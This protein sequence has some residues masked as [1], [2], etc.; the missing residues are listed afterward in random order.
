M[1]HSGAE[2]KGE[3]QGCSDRT[4]RML[5]AG[6]I[7]MDKGMEEKTVVS[8][9][10]GKN[11]PDV[12]MEMESIRTAVAGVLHAQIGERAFQPAVGCR[13]F[14][15]VKPWLD[16][17]DRELACEEAAGTIAGYES[18]VTNVRVVLENAR[19][20]PAMDFLKVSWVVKS[21]G[22]YDELVLSFP[23]GS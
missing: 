21:T 13:P 15:P 1:T 10:S 2:R 8:P 18:R 7:L 20:N 3:R 11:E 6:N 16:V 22:Q 19:E 14:D 9:A 23:F 4:G 17:T 5:A 12:R